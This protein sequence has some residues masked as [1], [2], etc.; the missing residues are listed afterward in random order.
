M[1]DSDGFLDGIGAG[2]KAVWRNR[3]DA[4]KLLDETLEAGQKKL[5]KLVDDGADVLDDLGDSGKYWEEMVEGGSGSRLNTYGDALRENLGPAYLSHPEEYNSI[6]NRANEL[7]VS[8]EFRPGTLAYDMEFGRPGRLI[9]D[10][11]ASIGALRHEYRHMLDDFELQ[12]P[13]LRIIE[14]SDKFWELE[15]RGYVEELNLARSIKD[16]E[17]GSIIIIEMSQRR[18]EILGR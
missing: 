7:G 10:P 3:D 8:V 17:A 18:L 13:G 6:I 15:F 5:A 1:S 2:L 12:H 16:Y 9:I 11:D 14:D 4:A